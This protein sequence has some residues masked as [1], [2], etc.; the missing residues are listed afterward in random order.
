MTLGNIIKEYRISHEMSMDAFSEK[1]GISKAYISLLEKNKHPKTGKAI[2]PSIQC[3]KQSADAMNMDFNDLFNMLDGNV[4]LDSSVSPDD[5]LESSK[6]KKRASKN[7]VKI[8]NISGMSLSDLSD[9]TGISKSALDHYSKGNLIPS[10]KN[11]EKMAEV[12]NV[13][14]LW[15]MGLN[16]SMQCKE[17]VTQD[18]SLSK[19]IDFYYRL[20]ST[21]RAKAVERMEELA[22]VPSYVQQPDAYQVHA[23]AIRQVNAI[24]ESRKKHRKTIS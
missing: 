4:V 23:D 9:E 8:M 15:L 13:N 16:V 20:N 17:S 5:S 11:A 10:E 21:G 24:E 1:S 7:L 14:P 2:A 6:T 19:I 22:Q 18:N 12:L 3:I